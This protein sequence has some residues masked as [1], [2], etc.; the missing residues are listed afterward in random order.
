MVNNSISPFEN[1]RKMSADIIL[2]A[3]DLLV[4]HSN[5]VAGTLKSTLEEFRSLRQNNL[6]SAPAISPENELGLSLFFNAVNFCYR[7]PDSGKDYHYTSHDGR[8]LR[9]TTAFFTS[10]VESGLEWNEV[11]QIESLSP[12]RWKTMLQ[13]NQ[14]NVLYLGLERRERIVGLAKYLSTQGFNQVTDF[15]SSCHEKVL[16]LINPLQECGFFQDEFLKRAQVCIKMIDG[17][18]TTRMNRSLKGLDMLTCMADYRIP[19]VFYNLGAVELSPQLRDHLESEK[20]VISGSREELALRASVIVI[21][22]QLA[23]LMAINEAE[24]DTLL[25]EYSQVMDKTG[26]MKIPHMLVATDKY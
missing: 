10:L 20:P 4:V 3:T 7:D 5:I 14:T 23:D 9:R 8:Q 12:G 21:G 16:E 11:K 6:L 25:W 17:V 19:Q 2:N 26:Q 24:V 18:L 13:L 22:R 1:I 15:I